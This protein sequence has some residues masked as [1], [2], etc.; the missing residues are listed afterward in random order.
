ML[1]AVARELQGRLLT[2]VDEEEVVHARLLGRKQIGRVG[3]PDEWNVHSP[4]I[5]CDLFKV[6]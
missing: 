5:L 3:P 2:G 4:A 6:D 1:V